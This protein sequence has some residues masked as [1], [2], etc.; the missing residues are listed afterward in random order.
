M[1][2]DVKTQTW[3]ELAKISGA[4][5]EW[6]REGDYLYF[7]GVPRIG[8]PGAVFRVRISDRKLEQVVSMRDSR[9]ASGWVGLAP[10]DSPLLVRDAGTEDIYALDWDAP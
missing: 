1:L 9:Q 10:D 7:S 5:Q 3:T 4:W 8:E 2:F 6:S